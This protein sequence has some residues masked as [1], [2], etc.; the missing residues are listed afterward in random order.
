MVITPNNEP[1]EEGTITPDS[2]KTSEDQ[3]SYTLTPEQYQIILERKNLD[4]QSILVNPTA[5]ESLAQHSPDALIKFAESSDER[6]Y[7]FHL[8]VQQQQHKENF[9][10]ENTTRIILGGFV[11]IVIACLLYSAHTKDQSLPNQ[12]INLIVGSAGLTTYLGRKK[13]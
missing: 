2:P 5:I 6:Q 9:A 7:Q 11:G 13:D 1:N 3:G 10:K 4:T 12:I 8:A